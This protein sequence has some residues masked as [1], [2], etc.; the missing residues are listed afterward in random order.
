[1]KPNRPFQIFIVILILITVAIAAVFLLIEK[2]K[3]K[4]D[5]PLDEISSA[6]LQFRMGEYNQAIK[7]FQMVLDGVPENSPE[8]IQALYGLACT[9][10]LKQLP[11]GDKATAA[12]LFNEIIT[13]SPDSEYAAWSTLALVRMQHIVISGTTPDY[14]VVRKLYQQVYDKYPKHTAGHEAFIYMIGTYLA[15]FTKEDAE[16]AKGKL[17]EFIKDNPNSPF[18]SSAWGLYARACQNLNLKQERLDAM[19]KELEKREIDPRNPFMDNSSAYWAIASVAEFEVGDFDTARKYYR[20]MLKE[21]P[22]ERR[23][24]GANKAIER[25]DA[26]EEKLREEN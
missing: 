8:R 15:A 7:R 1:V 3:E 4:V 18:I 6:W 25:M 11:Y 9:H 2:K 23:N 12:E 21:Y 17:D 24:F 26:M 19:L 5:K 14:P 10:W 22:R 16:Y 13:K 20:M